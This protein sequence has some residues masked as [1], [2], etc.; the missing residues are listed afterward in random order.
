M[1]GNNFNFKAPND[2][3]HP[4]DRRNLII[5]IIA[6][7]VIYLTFDHFVLQPKINSIR[8]EQLAAQGLL[9]QAGPGGDV[10]VA[11]KIETRDHVVEN[12]QRIKMDNGVVFGTIAT[13]GN[14]IDDVMLHKYFKTLG[15][16]D[17]VEGPDSRR[18]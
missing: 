8:Q 11:D 10:A 3:M 13:T 1:A 17:N 2:Q 18:D 7:L 4:D 5:F 16:T 14:R 6:A 9:K 12:S 15:G